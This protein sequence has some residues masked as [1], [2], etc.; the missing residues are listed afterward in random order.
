MN[1]KQ[2]FIWIC[3]QL[4]MLLKLVWLNSINQYRML[5]RQEKASQLPEIMKGNNADY[6][7]TLQT[8]MLFLLILIREMTHIIVFL[9][10][11]L[12]KEFGNF[13]LMLMLVESQSL[14]PQNGIKNSRKQILSLV[15]MVKEFWDSPNIIFLKINILKTLNSI[16]KKKTL[17]LN[18]NVLL[19]FF[20]L[21]IHQEM[22]FHMLSWNA[23]LLVSRL[24]WL[25]EISLLLLP[26]LP[27][28]AT[29]SL[30]NLSMK[31]LKEL[32][33][34]LK[35]ALKCQTQSSFMVMNSQKW[36]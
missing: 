7:S 1:L 10:K 6:L 15:K 30:K 26:Q 25:L 13:V 12:L 5:L 9:P 35:N 21:L 14:K 22:L 17:S 24:S 8:N 34:L 16:L 31:L 33:K 18:N 11:E 3:Q 23:D 29:L 27:N 4:V 2:N 36:L 32:E 19:V 20:H 28:N